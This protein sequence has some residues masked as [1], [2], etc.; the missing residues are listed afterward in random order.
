[1]GRNSGTQ[2]SNPTLVVMFTESDKLQVHRSLN[3][4]LHI[5]V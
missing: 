1:M 4:F 2:Y 5:L 3:V